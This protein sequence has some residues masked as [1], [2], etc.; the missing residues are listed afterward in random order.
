MR[1]WPPATVAVLS[2]TGP[3]AIP[4]S[5]AI[6]VDE[7]TI[8][9]ALATRRG[10]LAR[11]QEDPRVALT[12]MAAGD[13][14][15]TAHGHAHVHEAISDNIAAV[16]LEVDE[17]RDHADPRFTIEAAVGWRWTDATAEQR[18]AEV[19]DALQRMASRLRRAS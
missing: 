2:T 14:A 1:D 9:F 5:T 17:V 13:L 18:D 10:S 12:V 15:F 11:L 16:R 7:R 3:H 4:V 6:R 8:L 19:R